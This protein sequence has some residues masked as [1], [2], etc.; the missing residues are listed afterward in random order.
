MQ[1]ADR[2]HGNEL[3][4]QIYRR[5]VAPRPVAVAPSF[6]V[7]VLFLGRPFAVLFFCFSTGDDGPDVLESRL[8]RRTG[9]LLS[10]PRSPGST[11][12]PRDLDALDLLAPRF[13][14][15]AEILPAPLPLTGNGGTVSASSP[16]SSPRSRLLSPS[17]SSSKRVPGIFT[18]R[19][20]GLSSGLA[21]RFLVFRLLGAWDC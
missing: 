17:S 3:V 15:P 20:S 8:D 10:S 16:V 12:L 6:A 7:R 4:S 13:E 9:L 18:L 14:P 2:E 21:A 1:M 5:F 19:A 11:L